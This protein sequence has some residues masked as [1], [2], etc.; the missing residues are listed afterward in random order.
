MKQAERKFKIST[1]K[2]DSDNADVGKRI[3]YRKNLESFLAETLFYL[4]GKI[5]M[6]MLLE[7]PTSSAAL[8]GV[9]ILI[10]FFL[11]SKKIKFTTKILINVSLMIAFATI[12]NYL[13]IYHLP[14]GGAVTLGGMIPLLLISFRYGAGVGLFAGFIFGL[15][16]ILQD[17]FILHPVQVLFDY[18]LPF[19]AMGLAGFFSEIFGSSN[20][21]CGEI[22]LPFSFGR[23]ILRVVCSGRNVGGKLLADNKCNLHYPRNADMLPDFKNFADKKIA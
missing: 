1:R 10:L 16:N 9:L 19:M 3:F 4:G 22:S 18:P 5:F 17:P 20:F 15:I 2:P 8:I 23:D 12:L 14:Q 21:F 13:K 7:N 11:Y 6:Q